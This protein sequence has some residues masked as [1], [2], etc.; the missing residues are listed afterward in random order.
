[1]TAKPW[2]RPHDDGRRVTCEACGDRFGPLGPGRQLCALCRMA[3][4]RASALDPALTLSAWVARGGR[5][6][7]PPAPTPPA[8]RVC[9]LCGLTASNRY[10]GGIVA[11]TLTVQ[12]LRTVGASLKAPASHYLHVGC[13][14]SARDI[15]RRLT[16]V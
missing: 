14:F 1:M 10:N 15:V 3:W 6:P 4:G 9:A 11:H 12:A 5:A 8:A 7:T 16:P 13:A 2:A